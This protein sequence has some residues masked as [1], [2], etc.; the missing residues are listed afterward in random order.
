MEKLD[1]ILGKE[2]QTQKL[3]I[4]Y[5]ENFPQKNDDGIYTISPYK[6]ELSGPC[7]KEQLN[8]VNRAFPELDA[9]FYEVLSDRIKELGFTDERLIDAVN[10]VIDNCIYP[11]PTAAQILSWD[12]R[13]KVYTYTQ[14]VDMVNKNEG[15]ANIWDEYKMI[16]WPSPI[17]VWAHIT[18]IERYNLKIKHPEE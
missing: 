8:K 7:V 3:P 14:M 5:N 2:H 9:G 11:R 16:A 18:D 4:L 1:K 17:T 12:R 13:I 6:G 15:L 10:Y